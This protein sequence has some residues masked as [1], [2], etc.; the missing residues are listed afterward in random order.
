MNIS[1]EEDMM[2]ND[3]FKKKFGGE[4]NKDNKFIYKY[5]NSP[6]IFQEAYIQLRK[7][8]L[9]N[10]I[11][12]NFYLPY[13]NQDILNFIMFK[14]DIEEY[15]IFEETRRLPYLNT[16]ETYLMNKISYKL[17]KILNKVYIKTPK[18][19]NDYHFYKILS[20]IKHKVT[21]K[22]K[23]IRIYRKIKELVLF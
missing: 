3:E 13:I 19:T 6:I 23:D 11:N 7:D 1:E 4:E 17:K 5:G 18:K 15:S 2:S 22:N 16:S 21:L 9:N 12:F 8:R 20:C 10:D 14:Y